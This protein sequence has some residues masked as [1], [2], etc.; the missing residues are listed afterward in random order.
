MLKKTLIILLHL[1]YNI[2]MASKVLQSEEDVCEVTPAST[3]KR[4]LNDGTSIPVIA[5][6]VYQTTPGKEA[7]NSVRE[8]L[9]TGYLHIDSAKLYNNEQD[10][11][12]A[13]KDSGLNRE[14]IFITTKLWS[15]DYD[16]NDPYD[17][18]MQ[19]A[20]ESL[21]KLDTYI[22]LYLIHSP[23]N[24]EA[25][26]GFWKALEDWLEDSKVSQLHQSIIVRWAGEVQNF[27]MLPEMEESFQ[28]IM[29]R[30]RGFIRNHALQVW[31]ARDL[32][33]HLH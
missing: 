13:V 19:A 2:I 7:Y 33:E 23:H 27:S 17:F 6:G 10:V 18:V 15:L 20:E 29:A 3:T 24:K 11:G 12:K 28:E 1:Q 21:K 22:D 32:N 25:R 14:E 4:T 16:G 9:R 26:L 31:V 8:A 5:L 30:W